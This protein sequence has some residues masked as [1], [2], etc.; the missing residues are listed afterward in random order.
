MCYYTSVAENIKDSVRPK[1]QPESSKK[2]RLNIEPSSNE[3]GNFAAESSWGGTSFAV[4]SFVSIDIHQVI[5]SI[6]YE[7]LNLFATAH[8]T[9]FSKTIW[10]RILCCRRISLILVKYDRLSYLAPHRDLIVNLGGDWFLESPPLC[11]ICD[12]NF[13]PF[14]QVSD[15]NRTTR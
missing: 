2:F 1:F 4:I 10:N 12:T 13:T 6:A 5:G 15:W 11:H 14:P 9:P 7:A 3:P 8:Q